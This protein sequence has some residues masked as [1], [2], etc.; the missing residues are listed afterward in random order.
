M[1][2]LDKERGVVPHEK[3]PPN[4]HRVSIKKTSVINLDA[5]RAYLNEDQNYGPQ[6]QEAISE[7]LPIPAAFLTRN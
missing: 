3:R 7:S 6:V 4:Q 5:I 2:D 1:I